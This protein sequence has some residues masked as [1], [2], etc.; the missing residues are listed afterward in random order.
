MIKKILVIIVACVA[1][2][3]LYSCAPAP[4]SEVS[5]DN[6]YATNVLVEISNGLYYD[7]NTMIVYWWNGLMY[8]P[9][10]SATTPSPYYAPN[11]LPY[12]YNPDAKTFEEIERIES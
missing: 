8:T 11:G 3:T 9:A 10:R 4:N 6:T 5:S 1:T 12:K 2:F 7:S